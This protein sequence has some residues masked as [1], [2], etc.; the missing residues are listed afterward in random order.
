MGRLAQ[1]YPGIDFLQRRLRGLCIAAWVIDNGPRRLLRPQR[2]IGS[3]C[4]EAK[5]YRTVL[6]PTG[7]S[8]F[9]GIPFW[10]VSRGKQKENHHF[11][12]SPKKRQTPFKFAGLPVRS[13]G[14]FSKE[15]LLDLKLPRAGFP[16]GQSEHLLECRGKIEKPWFRLFSQN[17]ASKYQREGAV[18]VGNYRCAFQGFATKP[19]IR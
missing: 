8:Y 13:M 6:V 14:V 12:G 15:K 5:E 18:A 3:W 11:Q 2:P 10:L 17:R 7:A 1:I 9:H 19:Q 4:R 16:L